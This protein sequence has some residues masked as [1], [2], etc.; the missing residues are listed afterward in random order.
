MSHPVTIG[1]RTVSLAW[2][3]E[4]ARRFTYRASSIGG[5]PGKRELTNAKTATAAVT[6]LLWLVLPPEVAASYP[7]PE[8]LF[9]ALD[10]ETAGEGIHKALVGIMA[11]MHADD[12]KKSTS[13]SSPSPGSNSD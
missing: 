12:E 6:K 5:A 13:P 7:T 10:H 9:L 11:D 8:D 1:G 3:Q 4:I 2:T